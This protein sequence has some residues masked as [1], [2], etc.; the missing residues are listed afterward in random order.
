VSGRVRSR[1][2]A[3]ARFILKGSTALLVLALLLQAFT[4]GM[5]AITDAGWWRA[6]VTWVHIFQWLVLV[7]PASAAFADVPRRTKWA[8]AVPLPLVGLQYV[9][10][11]RGI[12]GTLPIGFGL[13]AMTAMLL[14]TVA[15]FVATTAW[16]FGRHSGSGRP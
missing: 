4:A 10:A 15:V 5:A 11:H 2:P 16:G 13:H 9:L 3:A 1:L 6:H 7:L 8:S 12:D 14:F